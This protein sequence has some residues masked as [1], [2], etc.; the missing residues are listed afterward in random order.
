MKVDELLK[1]WEDPAP[2]RIQL[3]EACCFAAAILKK[4]GVTSSSDLL[5]LLTKEGYFKIS[6]RVLNGVLQFLAKN[7]CRV[8]EDPLPWQLEQLEIYGQPKRIYILNRTPENLEVIEALAQIWYKRI[9]PRG[10]ML[11]KLRHVELGKIA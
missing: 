6:G 10:R 9:A 1:F 2:C 4:R 7:L 11:P 5:H 8:E 3:E